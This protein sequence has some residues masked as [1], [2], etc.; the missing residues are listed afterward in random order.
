MLETLPPVLR[1][2][3]AVIPA[4]LANP[5]TEGRGGIGIRIEPQLHS[6]PIPIPTPTPTSWDEGKSEAG[7]PRT[8]LPNA[9]GVADDSPGSAEERGLPGVHV[10]KNPRTLKAVRG[11]PSVSVSLSESGSNNAATRSR[12]RFRGTARRRLAP[13]WPS[14]GW[15]NPQGAPTMPNRPRLPSPLEEPVRSGHRHER[16]LATGRPTRPRATSVP[17]R[18]RC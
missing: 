11:I 4:R 2:R 14:R 15:T 7:K 17:A 3:L 18:D 16:E 13:P 5:G 6:I 12:S 8:S 9:K 10:P 1:L